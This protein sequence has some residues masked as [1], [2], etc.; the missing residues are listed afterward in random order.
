MNIV[1][2]RGQVDCRTPHVKHL[3]DHNDMYYHLMNAVLKKHD[4][5]EMLLWGGLRFIDY[6]W[7][8]SERWTNI[9]K[10][11]IEY[12][13]HG[14]D[15]FEDF[16]PDIVIARGGFPEYEKYLKRLPKNVKT[17][18]YGAGK[19]WLPENRTYDLVLVD[20]E[21]LRKIAESRGHR[22][23][24]WFKPAAPCFYPRDVEKKYDLCFVA[25]NPA[26][27]RKR[28]KWVYETLPQKYK[29]LQLGMDPKQKVP[30]NVKVKQVP[31]GKMAKY[32]SQCRVTICP[33]TGGD[34]APRIISESMACNVR[35]V[36]SDEI[37]IDTEKYNGFPTTMNYFWRTV[38]LAIRYYNQDPKSNHVR[39]WY[40]D[41]LSI[42]KAAEHLRKLLIVLINTF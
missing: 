20:S 26:D 32:I 13:R 3:E 33:Y 40:D 25:A 18:Y 5:C 10:C 23:A 12:P 34:G 31:K 6:N 38:E 7:N 30:P 39:E 41:H 11:K 28:A 24:V 9:A 21:P 8:L 16:I 17:V 22:S 29:V 19:R 2:L 1:F 37:Q 15:G 14:R 42:V 27:K 4:H 35:T 36:Y